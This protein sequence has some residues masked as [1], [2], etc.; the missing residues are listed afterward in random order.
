[1]TAVADW[2]ACRL[3]QRFNTVRERLR[4][5]CREA[6]DGLAGVFALAVVHR[7]VAFE[8]AV[9]RLSG[10]VDVHHEILGGV[11]GVHQH[12]AERRLFPGEG[13]VG[14]VPHVVEFDLP[15][16]SGL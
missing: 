12:G 5:T 1:L 16:S 15:S 3:G 4:D 10:L 2:R 8:R 6:G 11:P 9:K 13:I 7:P 14:H